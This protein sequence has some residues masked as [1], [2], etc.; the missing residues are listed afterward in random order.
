MGGTPKSS[1]LIGFFPY[2]S[3]ILGLPPFMEIPKCT[4]CS[5]SIKSLRDLGERNLQISSVQAAAF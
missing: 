3:S 2:E 4:R 1:I 5:A